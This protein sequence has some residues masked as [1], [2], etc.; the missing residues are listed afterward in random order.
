MKDKQL[1]EQKS[2]VDS[3]AIKCPYCGGSNFTFFSDSITIYSIV[4]ENG[5]YKAVA[6]ETSIYDSERGVQCSD[7]AQSET[8]NYSDEKGDLMRMILDEITIE[9]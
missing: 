4:N 9:G 7:C 3:E 1:E 6:P 5:K 2:K 8:S